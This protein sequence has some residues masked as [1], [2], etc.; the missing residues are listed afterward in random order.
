MSARDI[1]RQGFIDG[2]STYAHWRDGEQYV[3]TTG[4]TLKSATEF[5]ENAWNWNPPDETPAGDRINAP[6]V[7]EWESCKRLT[8]VP[9]VDEALRNF[10]DDPAEDNAICVVRVILRAAAESKK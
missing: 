3:G 6:A 4:R 2:L 1:Y 5:P 10:S 7:D 9:E 8:D